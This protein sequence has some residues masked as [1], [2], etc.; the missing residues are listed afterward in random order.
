M[1]AVV[2]FIMEGTGTQYAVT[3]LIALLSIVLYGNCRPF[4]DDE[5]DTL[6]AVCQGQLAFVACGALV[7][8]VDLP[9]VDGYEDSVFYTLLIVFINVLPMVSALRALNFPRSSYH[10]YL[11]V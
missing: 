7:C 8:A 10:L 6:Q 3:T 9:V 5:D 1:S 11:Y 2:V 4:V